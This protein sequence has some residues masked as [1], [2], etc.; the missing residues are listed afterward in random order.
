MPVSTIGIWYSRPQLNLSIPLTGAFMSSTPLEQLSD[1]ITLAH[2][3]IQ[4]DYADI[5]PVV[6]VNRQMRS[7]DIPADAITID[8]LK[9]DKRLLLIL[10]DQQP[11]EVRYQ[12]GYRT[13][14]PGPTFES[15]DLSALTETVLIDWIVGYFQSGRSS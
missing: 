9:T 3:R 14:D 7:A 10:H 1:C 15:I 8:C 12:F 11:D 5:N 13:E 4:S 2:R 6:G